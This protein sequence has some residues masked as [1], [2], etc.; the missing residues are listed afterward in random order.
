MH[1]LEQKFSCSEIH[2]PGR[3]ARIRRRK[4][5]SQQGTQS[6]RHS[7]SASADQE[8]ICEEHKLV[9]CTRHYLLLNLP[10]LL[11][12]VCFEYLVSEVPPF[13]CC[14]LASPLASPL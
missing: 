4:P 9:L 3:V 1:S 12:R 6:Y 13:I 5:V 10:L 2:S 14:T 7:N 8:E 11:T